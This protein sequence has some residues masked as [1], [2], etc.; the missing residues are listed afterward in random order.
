MTDWLIER[1]IKNRGNPGDP[2]VRRAYT[3]LAGKTGI[4]VNLL[5]FAVKLIIG[6]LTH[7]ISVVSD[8]ANNLSDS[9]SSLISLLAGKLSAREADREH[10]Y[11]HGRLEYIATLMICGI[12]FSA[13]FELFQSSVRQIIEP[14]PL[15]VSLSS[16]IILSLTILVK[17]WLSRFYARIGTEIHHTSILAS[18]VDSRN[19]MIATALTIVSMLVSMLKL[20]VPSDG[21][22]GA[23]VSVYIF[24]SGV[25]I[26]KDIISKLLGEE[27]S[28]DLREKIQNMIS[29]DP[30]VKG[31]H[32]LILHDYGPE[33]CLGSVH[34]ELDADMSLLKAHEIIDRCEERVR[35]E[36]NVDLT[37]HP[38]P[39][40]MDEET[41]R[42]RK[43]T[44]AVTESVLPGSKMHDFHI[45]KEGDDLI[46]KFDLACPF[47]SGRKDHE[48]K[49]QIEEALRRKNPRIQCRITF[50]HGYLSHT[51]EPGE[52]S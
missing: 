21:I 43:E 2:G 48:W 14:R 28:E 44:A 47:S 33:H 19:D 38:D 23:I 30:Q 11:G 3:E 34:C 41:S 46:L 9:L 39:V 8:A 31:V 7:S 16:V 52:T 10:P 42:W 49:L 40:S 18:A 20:P 27:S 45:R 1:F 5:L 13:A 36:L 37:I 35:R 4:F 32:D 17:F 22:A 51:E 24:F 15:N 50:D 26:A 29:E 25:E 6:L 12:I